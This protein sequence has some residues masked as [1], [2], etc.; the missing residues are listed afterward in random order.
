MINRAFFS[1]LV[2]L[3]LLVWSG[4][5]LAN[6]FAGKD[7]ADAEVEYLL[8]TVGSSQCTFVR[9][10]QRHTAERAED[11]L[12]MKYNKAR[13]YIANADEFITKIASESS[14][15]G[16]PYTIECPGVESQPSKNWLFAR[17]E[18]W[19]R[20]NRTTVT[21]TNTRSEQP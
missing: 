17:L 16:Q 9:N 13:R 10:G 4:N 1:G 8:Q 6:D 2:A 5:A 21:E 12:R 19:R 11:H 14:W 15:T 3:H 18:E 20:G 7:S